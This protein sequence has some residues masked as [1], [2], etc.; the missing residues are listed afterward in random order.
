MKENIKTV[1]MVFAVN[2]HGSDEVRRQHLEALDLNEY[3]HFAM[4]HRKESKKK[5]SPE[6]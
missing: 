3:S 4:V 6:V 5:G 1:L 2:F